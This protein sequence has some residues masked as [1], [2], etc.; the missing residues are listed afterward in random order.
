MSGVLGAD[1]WFV[2]AEERFMARLLNVPDGDLMLECP[3]SMLTLDWDVVRDG[4]WGGTFED[5]SFLEKKPM[6]RRVEGPRPLM[7]D[8]ERVDWVGTGLA[9]HR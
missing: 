1:V 4:F 3:E 6:A 2:P 8:D 9:R 5:L 7:K